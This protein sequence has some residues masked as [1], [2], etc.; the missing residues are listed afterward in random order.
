MVGITL[1]FLVEESMLNVALCMILKLC[2]VE[3][4]GHETS[5]YQAQRYICMQQF[6]LYYISANNNM[7]SIITILFNMVP[8]SIAMNAAEIQEK[9]GLRELHDRKWFIHP[10]CATTGDGLYEGLEW[11][12][13]HATSW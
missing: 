13:T 1:K 2:P 6:I 10:T 9:M 3:G 11:L 12:R 4:A 5:L 8:A 7:L